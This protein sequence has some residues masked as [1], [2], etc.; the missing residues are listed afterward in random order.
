MSK[1]R[2]QSLIV[3]CVPPSQLRLLSMTRGC[4]QDVNKVDQILCIWSCR[5]PR[6]YGFVYVC[7]IPRCSQK[8]VFLRC[9]LPL[10]R[11]CFKRVVAPGASHPSLP[12]QS[13]L[14]YHKKIEAML[15]STSLFEL[16]PE[17][18]LMIPHMLLTYHLCS[19]NELHTRYSVWLCAPEG[20]EAGDG[21]SAPNKVAQQRRHLCAQVKSRS[22]QQGQNPTRTGSA[23]RAKQSKP[24]TL[25]LFVWSFGSRVRRLCARLTCAEETQNCVPRCLGG[26]TEHREG[27]VVLHKHVATS[28]KI[29][30]LS[31]H[32]HVSM[33]LQ[34]E[35]DGTRGTQECRLADAGN[36]ANTSGNVTKSKHLELASFSRKQETPVELDRAMRRERVARDEEGTRVTQ[37]PTHTRAH[38]MHESNA[39][40]PSPKH[41]NKHAHGRTHEEIYTHEHI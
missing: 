19:V 10:P 8:D 13:L 16:R 11:F 4:V 34:G 23:T 28:L 20:D 3:R 15:R 17:A 35:S 2:S 22:T 37:T 33:I 6:L 9:K 27:S 21:V 36:E 12:L 26:S 14:H 29:P 5:R 7:N 32:L 25:T 38:D 30:R 1:P 39:C 24:V 41:M 18:A 31:V 40:T